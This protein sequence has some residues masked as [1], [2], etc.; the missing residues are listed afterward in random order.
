MIEVVLKPR[1]QH[2]LERM[3]T[4]AEHLKAELETEVRIMSEHKGLSEETYEMIGEL[5][6]LAS[7]YMPQRTYDDDDE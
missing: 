4:L 6:D 5:D 7:R 2:D 3:Q 1:W